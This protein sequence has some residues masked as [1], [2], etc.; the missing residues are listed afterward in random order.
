METIPQNDLIVFN[1]YFYIERIITHR[2]RFVLKPLIKNIN[3]FNDVD[4][5]NELE[6]ETEEPI[7][8]LYHKK[9]KF[10]ILKNIGER[11]IRN[12]IKHRM[13]TFLAYHEKI[14]KFNERYFIK[15]QPKPPR[16]KTDQIFANK[17]IASKIKIKPKGLIAWIGLNNTFPPSRFS[18]TEG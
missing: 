1:H 5:Q 13:E 3:N 15:Y 18:P 8:N 4:M 2:Q 7:Y 12:F 6:T 14:A 9:T 17:G 11:E 10:C 16:A